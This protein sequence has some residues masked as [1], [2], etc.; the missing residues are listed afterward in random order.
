MARI[1]IFMLVCLSLLAGCNGDEEQVTVQSGGM[2]LT[3]SFANLAALQNGFHYEGWAIV[4]GQ[5]LSTG[6]F[7]IA[8]QN[9]VVTLSG[10]V[11]ANG[12][13]D[14]GQDISA[15][16]AIVIT[17]EPA[18]DNDMNPAETKILAG[19]VNPTSATL[20]VGDAA[21]LGDD[22]TS[23]TGNYILAT[24][25]DNNATNEL[26]GVWFLQMPGPSTGL[27]LPTLPNGWKYEGWAVTTGP[28]TTGTFLSPSGADEAAP[29]SGPNAG[30]PFPGED[31]L[32]N[33][34]SGFA[35]PLDLSGATVVISVEPFPDDDSAPFQ[36]K[37]L[38]GTVP[39]G[40]SSGTNYSMTSQASSTFPTGSASIQ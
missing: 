10:Q 34:P 15:A 11:I 27:N 1:S 7:N 29:Y 13:F 31:F 35:F 3:L 26:S 19:P 8:A 5:P 16:T 18:G 28:L 25:T 6:K 36:L 21:A 2:T 39:A 14:A 22:F 38:V 23:A 37:P 20:T 9:R 30:P 32:Q 12:V 4:G 33:T 24:P 40:A 17:I